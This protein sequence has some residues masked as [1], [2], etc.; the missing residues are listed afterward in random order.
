MPARTLGP[1]RGWIVRSHIDWGG[2]RNTLYK[3]VE[4]FPW[5]TRFKNFKGKPERENP[6][7]TISANDRRGLEL[8]Q[9]VSNG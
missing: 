2:E 7:W 8:L 4:T 3:G 6:K 1:E 5:Y 9:I